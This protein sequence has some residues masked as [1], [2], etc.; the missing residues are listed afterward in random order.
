MRQKNSAI[1]DIDQKPAEGHSFV[2]TIQARMKWITQ[3]ITFN[4]QALLY[5]LSIVLF[6]RIGTT[7]LV[8]LATTYFPVDPLPTDPEFISMYT[9]LKNSN[10]F[11]QKFLLPWLRWDTYYYL[12]IAMNGYTNVGQT[13]W[14][15]FFPFLISVLKTT[16]LNP[17]LSALV[18][19][20]IS[21]VYALY[22]LYMLVEEEKYCSPQ[23]VLLLLVT[24]PVA[25]YFMSAYSEALYLAL[26]ISAF[27]EARKGNLITAGLLSILATLTRQIGLLL[28]IPLFFEGLRVFKVH[29]KDFSLR[30]VFSVVLYSL[31]PV[32]AFLGFSLF[33]HFRIGNG[34]IWNRMNEHGNWFFTFPGWV[35]VQSILDGISGNYKWEI[36]T[37]L[38]WGLSLTIVILIIQG[39][40]QKNRISY[41]YLVY[42]LAGTLVVLMIVMEGK[43]L[44]SISRYLLVVF[45]IYILQ[46][47]IWTNKTFRMIWISSS[48]ALNILLLTGFY[49]GFWIE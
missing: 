40:F 24:F 37:F 8:Y 30:R 47:R 2:R 31:F 38:D 49:A 12:S 15:P 23:M 16:G 21:S 26:S 42:A 1:D 39:F 41:S 36:T 4:K 33:A 28:S 7:T 29:Y 32:I 48:F 13:V 9:S 10:L 5:A 14:P 34:Q 27:R 45:P 35:W 3:K 19:S 6:W 25:F 43:L 44:C 11:D 18:I 22:A 46:A 17:L 20:T